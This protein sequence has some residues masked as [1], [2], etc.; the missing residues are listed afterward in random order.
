MLAWLAGAQTK[1]N[2]AAARQKLL[3]NHMLSLQWIQFETKAFGSAKVSEQ[4]GML[5]L[6][7]EQKNP[8][9]QDFLQVDGEITQV[10]KLEFRFTGSIVYRAKEISGERLCERKGEF[11]FK[12]TGGRKYWRLQQMDSP[13]GTVTDYVD[14]YF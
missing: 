12:I 10:D 4:N 14:L 11:T 6:S 7:G 9:N 8:K 13:C 2:D 5:R 1:V 3:G